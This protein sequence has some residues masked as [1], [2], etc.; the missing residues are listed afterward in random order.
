ASNVWMTIDLIAVQPNPSCCALSATANPISNEN[1]FGDNIGSAYGIP[2][3]GHTPYTYVWVPNF[4]VTDT[5]TG[6]SAGTYSIIISDTIGCSATATV[7][8]TQP[9]QLSAAIT[10]ENIAC[11]GGRGAATAAV[12]GGTGP[13]TYSWTGG[14]KQDTLD[15]LPVGTYTLNV[16]DSRGCTASSSVSITQPAAPLTVTLNGPSIICIGY[17]ENLT[18]AASGGTL[19]YTYSWGGSPYVNNVNADTTSITA[20]NQTDTV[21][22]I[23]AHGCTASAAIT[24]N[25]GPDVDVS[26]TGPPSIC[27]TLTTTLCANVHGGTGGN[28]YVWLPGNF[29]TPCI[30]VSPSATSTYSLTIMDNCGT[31][32]ATTYTLRVNPLP[33]TGFTSS[34]NQGCAPLCVQF[35]NTTTL[36]QGNS[37]SYTWIFGNGDSSTIQNPVYCYPNNGTYNV[38]LMVISDSGCSST[39]SKTSFVS[40]FAKPN[41]A[42]TY[43]PQPVTILTPTVQFN[44]LTTDPYNII[45]W[46]WN[47]GD[48]TDSVSNLTNPS[49]TYPDTGRYCV[50]MVVED[51]HGCS[52]TITNCLV[53]EPNFNLYIPSAFTP[54]GDN[55]DETFKPV[56]QYIKNFEMYIFDRWGMQ[57]YHTTDIT[58]GWNGTVNGGSIAQED[59]YIYK[60]SL[61]D[62]E[63][64]RH[65]YVGNVTLLK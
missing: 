13:Y 15:N 58:Q 63:G 62:S 3:K 42:F 43:S 6:L 48:A 49:H 18:A 8:I 9:A 33:L 16:T 22:V 51:E 21:Q 23:D 57:L 26:I 40:A 5:A 11:F 27:Q 30:S 29:V 53:I 44:N 24:V 55:R 12:T 60:I 46:Q 47:F 52:D 28:T 61:T 64:N 56:G 14:H 17:P 7:S 41:G 25:L 39:L 45:Y 19:P 4:Q 31:I 10:P 36:A 35:Y 38:S 37:S 54:N 2:A 32:A 34:L 59:T 20:G 50:N 65:S 1:C